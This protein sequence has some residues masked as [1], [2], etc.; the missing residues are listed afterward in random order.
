[1]EHHNSKSAENLLPSVAP[2]NGDWRQMDIPTRI[3]SISNIY[4][5]HPVVRKLLER[6]SHAFHASR[7][8]PG[9]GILIYGPQAGWPTLIRSMGNKIPELQVDHLLRES[10]TKMLFLVRATLLANGRTSIAP[11][12]VP[13]ILN[14]L[15]RGASSIALAGEDDLP[16]L[17]EKCPL[18]KKRFF[19]HMPLN[20][21]AMDEDW[22]TMIRTLAQLL[23]FEETELDKHQMPERLHNAS[24]GQAPPLMRLTEAAVKVAYYEDKSKI[25]RIEH[26]KTAFGYGYPGE[27]N[28][29]VPTVAA[30]RLRTRESEAAENTKRDA[31]RIAN[32]GTVKANLATLMSVRSDPCNSHFVRTHGR[33]VG[34]VASVARRFAPLALSRSYL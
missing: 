8:G 2:G 16:T 20:P 28:P 1:M 31:L 32:R 17:I 24:G 12:S 14:L 7:S 10:G 6:L 27:K 13:F 26:Y 29:F 22:H 19:D 15:D 30:S 34:V 5:Y 25:L 4:L 3:S 9:M 18:L 33:R 23:P 21:F 11:E